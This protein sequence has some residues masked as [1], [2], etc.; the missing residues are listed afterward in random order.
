ML[1]GGEDRDPYQVGHPSL[2]GRAMFV[3]SAV[4]R[5][6]AAV[7]AIDGSVNGFDRIQELVALGYV[8][9]TRADALTDAQAGDTRARDAAFASG[10]QVIS[11]DYPV[12]GMLANGYSVEIPGGTPSRCNPITTAGVA[13]DPLDIES[14][15]WLAAP[16]WDADAPRVRAA[17]GRTSGQPGFD[18]ALDYDGDGRIGYGD[19]NLLRLYTTPA[20][21]CG[22]LGIE[23]A[24]VLPFLRRRRRA[25]A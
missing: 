6:D 9:R 20:R 22:L 17:L 7:I 5:D 4:G 8:I 2:A 1:D 11:T 12:P 25:R 10:A 19:L 23:L 16:D 14:P 3:T 18:A 15:A 13:C 21:A 24:L